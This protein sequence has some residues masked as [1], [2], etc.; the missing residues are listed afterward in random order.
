M[1]CPECQTD[2][3][4]HRKFCRECGAKLSLLC[5]LCG[6]ENLPGDK[7]CGECGHNLIL[8]PETL[9]EELSFDEKLEKIQRYLPK[10][11]SEKILAQRDRIEGERKQVTVMFCDIESFT[12]ISEKLGPED[13]Y[14]IMDK[15]YEILIHKVHDYEGTVNEMT[16]D[17]IMALFG[18]PIALEDAPQR[19]IRSSLSIHREIAKFNDRMKQEKENILPLRMRIGIHSGPVVVGTLGNDL[20][21][22]FKAVGDTVNLASR[23]EGLAEPGTTY[24]TEDTFKLAEGFFRFEALGERKIKGKEEPV[25][26]YRAIAPSTRRTRFDISAERGLTS[27][28][29]RD[30]ELKLL[31]EGFERAK[32]GRGQAYSIMAEAG[33]GKSRLLYEFRKAATHEN[34]TFLEGKCLSY[35]KNIAYHPVKDTL[36]ANFNIKEGDADVEIKQKVINGL[37][38]LGIDE[39]SSLPS[40]LELLSVKDSGIDKISMIP[41]TKKGRIIEAVK[42]IALKGSEIKPLILATEDLHWID[43]SSEEYLQDLMNSISGARIFLIFTYRPEFVHPW[44]AKS[45]HSQVNLNRLSNGESLAMASHLL[46][47]EALEKELEELILEKTEGVPFFIE[48]FIK[49]LKDLQIIEKKGYTY[50]ISKDVQAVSIP[51]KIQ[52]VIMARVDSLPEGAKQIVQTASVVG[53]EFNHELIKRVVDYPEKHLLSHL[54]VLK[55]SELLYEQGIYPQSTYIFKHA[56]T[57][58]VVYDSL[59]LKRREEIHEKIGLSIEQIYAEKLEEFYEILAYHYSKCGRYEKACQYLRLSGEKASRSY[60]NWEALQF[61]KQ[62]IKLLKKLPDTDENRK[63]QLHVYRLISDCL[64]PLGYPEDS[65]QILQEGEKLSVESG[66]EWSL[67]NFHRN[68]GWYFGLKGKS[69]QAIE[70]QEKSLQD[71]KKI[72]DFKLTMQVTTELCISYARAGNHCKVTD[73]ASGV[74]DHLEGMK[75]K[76]ELFQKVAVNYS[77]LCSIYGLGL[78]LLGNFKKGK[79]YCEKAIVSGH[80]IGDIFNLGACEF[81]YGNLYGFM[82]ECKLAIEHYEKSIKYWEESKAVGFA[83]TTWSL[84][85][86]TYYLLGDAVSAQTYA[87][88]GLKLKRESGIESFTSLLHWVLSQIELDI[89]NNRDAK[90]HA[91]TAL[92]L[93]RKHNERHFEGL[94]LVSLGRIYGN[95]DPPQYDDAKDYILKGIEIFEEM[96]YKPFFSQGYFYLGEL[97]ANSGR[98]EKASE[99]LAKAESMFLEMGMDY[100]LAKTREVMGGL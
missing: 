72:K 8:P 11:L 22:E 28:V 64:Y 76:P 44:G 7:F 67:V 79:I 34:V 74:I 81:H 90:S 38:I 89:G 82:G 36:K 51:A 12:Q 78:G 53:R 55:D 66:D 39:V 73:V 88:K 21:V 57:Q 96:K 52:D 10:G 62:A 2:N 48:E 29:G 1:K 3:S 75:G 43:K 45:Y 95:S 59:L 23:T 9:P 83:A 87:E 100:W 86:Y 99:N 30:R 26:I 13:A 70:Y 32:T 18:A 61:Y 16:G 58:E 37:K 50:R 31:L 91:E 93:S 80:K 85:G 14:T 77:R 33:L 46:D 47:T 69:L 68:I 98:K 35:S 20:R 4:D 15:V 60:S 92:K 63:E 40:I 97:Y 6:V 17:G 27:F 41:E 49:S 25:Q 94:A 56:L 71:A 5:S 84:L 54:S 65:L 19:A 24:I 42:R